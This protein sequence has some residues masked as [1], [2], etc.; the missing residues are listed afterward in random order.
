MASDVLGSY[1]LPL[2]FIGDGSTGDPSAFRAF[3]HEAR[4]PAGLPVSIWRHGLMTDAVFDVLREFPPTS[5]GEDSAS[6]DLAG[7]RFRT[8]M[9]SQGDT[10]WAIAGI[11]GT[12]VD[13]I[14][15][16]NALAD[17]D[18]LSIGQELVIP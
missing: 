18:K 12:S 2:R 10:L 5:G 16:A 3:L 14:A 11:Y 1:D 15:A 7:A 8:H 13:S 6:G 17:P 9:V 4:G